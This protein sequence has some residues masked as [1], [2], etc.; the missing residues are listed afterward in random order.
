MASKAVGPDSHLGAVIQDQA[1]KE[2]KDDVGTEPLQQGSFRVGEMDPDARR[3][4][5]D[6]LRM[7]KIEKA[8]RASMALAQTIVHLERER[9]TFTPDELSYF[10]AAHSAGYAGE[11]SDGFTRGK[12]PI[13]DKAISTDKGEYEWI[14]MLANDMEDTQT[15]PAAVRRYCRLMFAHERVLNDPGDPASVS[16]G[17]AHEKRRFLPAKPCLLL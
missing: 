9:R 3:E 5:L 1:M 17:A 13:F 14:Y 7:E 15:R 12:H 16:A 2:L 10:E 6:R 4:Y 11:T 8:K